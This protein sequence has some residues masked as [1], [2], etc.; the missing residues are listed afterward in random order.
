MNGDAI[1]NR[2]LHS[3]RRS[4]ETLDEAIDRVA[5][6]LTLAPADAAFSARLRARLDRSSVL[7]WPLL[8]AAVAGTLAAAVALGIVGGRPTPSVDRGT[9]TDDRPA[10]EASSS[11][12]AGQAVT[13]RA[14]QLLTATRARPT[15]NSQA[16]A[17]SVPAIVALDPPD[18]LGVGRLNV[19]PLALQ[20]V[21][22]AE[23]E[24]S[25]L[26]VADESSNPKE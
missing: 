7:P 22:V 24:V 10:V 25:A 26:P 20:P 8:A 16:P 12:P 1:S 4:G 3:G 2:E 23:L 18:E 9:A 17:F 11:L 15:P 21:E 14:S 19:Q 6:S 13:S 5:S